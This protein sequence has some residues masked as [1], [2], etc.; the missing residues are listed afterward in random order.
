MN[1][2]RRILNAFRDKFELVI[3]TISNML[4]GIKGINLGSGRNWRKIGWVGID[5]LEGQ[6]LDQKQQVFFC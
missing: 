1:A 5:Q 6:M 4:F 2:I 3:I